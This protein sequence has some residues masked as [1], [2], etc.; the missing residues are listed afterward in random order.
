MLMYMP[1]KYHIWNEKKNCS[2][3]TGQLM[4]PGM[5]K[6]SCLLQKTYPPGGKKKN[7]FHTK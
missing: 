6:L 2:I 3:Y 7:V 1:S 5:R 4:D